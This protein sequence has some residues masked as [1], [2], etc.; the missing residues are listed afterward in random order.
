MFACLCGLLFRPRD[1]LCRVL[2][3][4]LRDAVPLVVLLALLFSP[5]RHTGFKTGRIVC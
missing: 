5:V 2:P 1:C 4:A 3:S